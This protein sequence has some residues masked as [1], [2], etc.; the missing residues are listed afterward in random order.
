MA[1]RL[2]HAHEDLHFI[3][4]PALG[5]RE[6]S[7]SRG[8]TKDSQMLLLWGGAVGNGDLSNRLLQ[9][10][11]AGELKQPRVLTEGVMAPGVGITQL[12]KTTRPPTDL[13]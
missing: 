3:H 1:L 5:R 9:E 8:S 10:A 6:A 12:W 4:K 7:Y 2:F 11:E 13:T